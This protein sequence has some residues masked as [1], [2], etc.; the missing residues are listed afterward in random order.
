MD[1]TLLT[2]IQNLI[3]AVG[4]PGAIV[5][6]F[7][8]AGRELGKILIPYGERFIIAF[9]SISAEIKEIRE[10]IKRLTQRFPDKVSDQ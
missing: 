7:M 3:A 6:Y 8:W 5:L 2:Q 4:I 1:I 9:E 10:D